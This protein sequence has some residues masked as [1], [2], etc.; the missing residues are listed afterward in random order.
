[1]INKTQSFIKGYFKRYK[2][3][4]K[5]SA[6]FK[7]VT[8]LIGLFI[9]SIFY[10]LFKLMVFQSEIYQQK[11]ASQQ[12]KIT[13]IPANRG[14]IY[15]INGEKLVQSAAAW[16]VE[17]KPQTLSANYSDSEHEEICHTIAEILGVSY[18]NVLKR[19]R[20]NST[21]AMITKKADKDQKDKL[22]AY[23]YRDVYQ[24]YET[25][26]DDKGFNSTYG[27]SKYLNEKAA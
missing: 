18:E 19:S 10:N 6:R 12:L 21:S 26:K 22:N 17:L 5:F 8:F 2:K 23:I 15:D 16:I 1:M 7:I 27:L 24:Y 14:T 20:M 9:I 11:A 4:D 3:L 13:V 25:Y